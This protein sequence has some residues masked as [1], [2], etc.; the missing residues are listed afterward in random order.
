MLSIIIPTRRPEAADKAVAWIQERTKREHE[1]I[2]VDG[3]DGLNEKINRGLHAAT[4]EF[5]AI[6][7][8]DV[9]VLDGWDDVLCDVGSFHYG[10]LGGTKWIWGGKGNGYHTDPLGHPDYTG[11]I[12]F[13]RR[14]WEK[15]GDLDEAYR[16]PGHNDTDL[17]EQIRAA[18]LLIDCLHGKI[19]HHHLRTAPLSEENRQYFIK[20]WGHE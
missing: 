18:G 14:A 5:M 16:E 11:F 13:S 12:Q 17:G 8:D 10:E 4:G 6:L 20:K 1:I 7:H 3:E 19:I 9:E 2:L 15:F